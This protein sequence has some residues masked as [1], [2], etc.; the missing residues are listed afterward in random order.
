MQQTRKREKN[1]KVPYYSLFRWVSEWA[2]DLKRLHRNQGSWTDWP[3]IGTTSKR[4]LVKTPT[5]ASIIAVTDASE[6]YALRLFLKYP[7][8]QKKWAQSVFGWED[9]AKYHKWR[10]FLVQCAWFIHSH[11]SKSGRNYNTSWKINGGPRLASLSFSHLSS[12]ARPP[13]FSCRAETLTKNKMLT[14]LYI[15]IISTI[16]MIQFTFR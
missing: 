13:P 9:V 2:S 8:F 5:T 7:Q 16:H 1:L 4:G 10:R 6:P 11:T 3:L 12:R 14:L 15:Y